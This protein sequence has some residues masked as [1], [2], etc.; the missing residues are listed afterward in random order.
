MELGASTAKTLLLDRAREETGGVFMSNEYRA[1]EDQV[2]K[3][4][5]FVEW[6]D[7]SK[8]NEAIGVIGANNIL[9]IE[10]VPSDCWLYSDSPD[11][12]RMFGFDGE[13]MAA[14]TGAYYREFRFTPSVH[15]YGHENVEW[16]LQ[17][18]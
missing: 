5:P 4:N 13:K 14:D 1:W 17:L 3:N 11:V 7:I 6:D 18:R 9:Q 12:E 16:V 2:N 10:D 15:S 8:A